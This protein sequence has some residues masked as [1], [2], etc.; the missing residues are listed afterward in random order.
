[1][2]CTNEMKNQIDVLKEENKME[3]RKIKSLV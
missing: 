2:I 1:M 3:N